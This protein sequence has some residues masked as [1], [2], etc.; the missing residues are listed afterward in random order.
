MKKQL[1]AISKS[2]ATGHPK[3]AITELCAVIKAL[4]VEIEKIQHPK[5]TVL[6]QDNDNLANIPQISRYPEELRPLCRP[7]RTRPLNAGDM[8]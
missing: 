4:V 1:R 7:N 2:A 6:K 8:E 3:I 5:V